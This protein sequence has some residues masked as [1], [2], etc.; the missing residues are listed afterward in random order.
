[1]NIPN[2]IGCLP[3]AAV[4]AIGAR[5]SYFEGLDRTGAAHA[6]GRQNGLRIRRR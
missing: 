3:I 5:E 2:V 4:N 1:M 6:E